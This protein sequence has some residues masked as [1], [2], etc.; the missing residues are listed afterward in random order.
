MVFKQKETQAVG[1]AVDLQIEC[2][3]VLIKKKKKYFKNKKKD[4]F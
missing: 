3:F 1:G 2:S 4:N